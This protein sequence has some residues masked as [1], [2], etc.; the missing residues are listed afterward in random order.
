MSLAQRL[1][2]LA[3]ANSQGLLKYAVAIYAHRTFC[4][5]RF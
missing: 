3:I 2:E 5:Q 4:D 1:N